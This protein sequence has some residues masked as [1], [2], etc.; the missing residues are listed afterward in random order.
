MDVL[1]KA[2]LLFCELMAP[3]I[4]RFQIHM[5]LKPFQIKRQPLYF[6]THTVDDELRNHARGNRHQHV[7]PAILHPVIATRWLVQPVA[8][9]VMH[10]IAGGSVLRW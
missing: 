5:Y 4:H 1:V 8:T 9:P 6:L 7:I 3:D 10:H 2:V